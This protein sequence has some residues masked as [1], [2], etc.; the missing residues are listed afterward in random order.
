MKQIKTCQKIFNRSL[1]KCGLH[2]ILD[3]IAPFLLEY[4][5]Q[6]Y[7]RT[8]VWVRQLRDW[9]FY[10]SPPS[11]VNGTNTDTT[12]WNGDKIQP[13]KFVGVICMDAARRYS[14]EINVLR[15]QTFPD[16]HVHKF[17]TSRCAKHV[18]TIQTTDCT[19]ITLSN[20]G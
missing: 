6:V 3:L 20:S 9:C 18:H 17:N 11:I 14:K 8:S 5:R 13:F 12:R 1:L 7:I 2:C 4:S 19:V 10:H 15:A 16:Q